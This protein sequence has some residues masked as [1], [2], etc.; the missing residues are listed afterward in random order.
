MCQNLVDSVFFCESKKLRDIFWVNILCFSAA[1]IAGE[2]LKGVGINFNSI[3]S[4]GEVAAGGGKMTS[5]G[6]HG[7]GLLYGKFYSW[8]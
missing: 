6:K 8:V 5:D 4:H 7:D 3:L 2:E 1:W